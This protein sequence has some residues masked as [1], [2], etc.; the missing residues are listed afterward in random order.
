M[1]DWTLG[2]LEKAVDAVELPSSNEAD[3]LGRLDKIIRDLSQLKRTVLDELP[4]PVDGEEYRVVE[5]RKAN[6]SYNTAAIHQA[7]ASKGLDIFDLIRQDAARLSWH[8][9]GLKRAAE[10]EDVDLTIAHHEIEDEGELGGPLVGEVWTSY[11]RI[12]GKQ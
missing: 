6:R 10:S 3:W 2:D 4:G 8:W 11:Y 1:A 5:Q 9:T 7:F 12:E